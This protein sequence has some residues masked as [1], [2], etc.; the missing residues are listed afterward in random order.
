MELSTKEYKEGLSKR[1]SFLISSLAREDKTI[2]N[3]EDVRK[4]IKDSAKRTMHSLIQ[5]K[6]VLPLKKGLYV[7]VPLDVGV[8]G[9][10]SFILHNFVIAS[11]L[12][13]PYYIGF[14]SALNYYGFSEQIP[15]TTFVATTHIIKPL[16]ILNSNYY[17]VKLVK[18]KFFGIKRIE[19]DRRKINIS[20]P[21][22]TIVDCL[23]H[24]EHCGGI[25]ELARAIYFS[26]QELN[27]KR[28]KS[29]AIKMNNM[30]ILKRLGYILNKTGLVENYEAIFKGFR[31]SKGYS[32]L[33]PLSPRKGKYNS[34]WN[35]L[36]NSTINI[37]GWM[38]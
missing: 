18:R 33:D 3:I 13:K 29:Y 28:I 17:F 35:L 23:D 31:P 27:P 10:D 21:D 2:F 36:I 9:A 24:P 34:R 37:E 30:T 38:Y 25:D 20:G 14:W 15:R 4:I 12:A 22:K 1:E 5:K 16:E 32:L 26:H 19:I 11:S 7:I 8:K 6:W